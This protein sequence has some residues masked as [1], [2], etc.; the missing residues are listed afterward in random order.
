MT[1]YIAETT[2]VADQYLAAVAKVQDSV[3]EAVEAFV[4][5]LPELP[6]PAVELPTA[7]LPSRRR[8]QRR[9]LRLRREGARPA[10]RGRRQADRRAH[11]GRL[12]RTTCFPVTAVRP[13]IHPRRTAV[14][15]YR[16]ACL[17]RELRKAPT[18]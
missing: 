13:E 17:S 6:K 2:K 7:D 1:D 9:G 14:T 12:N 18:R 5:N 3:I 16:T 11:A 8:G 4:K 15:R 10:P